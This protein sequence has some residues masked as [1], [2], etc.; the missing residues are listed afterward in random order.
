MKNRFTRIN[1]P[2][3]GKENDPKEMNCR[4]CNGSMF[5]QGAEKYANQIIVPFWKEIV[6]FLSAIVGLSIIATIVQLIQ[7]QMIIGG[8]PSLS[9]LDAAKVASTGGYM[10][11]TQFFTYGT[12]FV[13]MGV[14]LWSAWKQIGQ[15]FTKGKAIGLAFA[16]LGVIIVTEMLYNMLTGAV[17]KAAGITP[18]SNENQSALNGMIGLSP[19]LSILFLGIIGPFVEE[20]A[21]RVGLFGFLSRIHKALAYVGVPVIFGLIHFNFGAGFGGAGAEAAIIEWVNLPIYMFSGLVFSF[22]YDKFGFASSYIAH[23]ANNVFSIVMVIIQGM[24][25]KGTI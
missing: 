17:L 4:Y 24:L 1:C 19:V 11:F 3:C 23:A 16:G 7:V 5:N 21:Y 8:D 20:V 13:A 6:L 18:A 22:L 9:P 2:H 12:I 14:L 10:V 15:S 25:P